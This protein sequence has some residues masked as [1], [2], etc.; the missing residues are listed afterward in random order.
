MCHLWNI[1]F[2][3]LTLHELEDIMPGNGWELLQT[4]GIACWILN[5]ALGDA[6]GIVFVCIIN[7]WEEDYWTARAFG[8]IRYISH[9][10]WAWECR[11]PLWSHSPVGRDAATRR[12]QD[13][14]CR[15]DQGEQEDVHRADHQICGSLWFHKGQDIVQFDVAHRQSLWIW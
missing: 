8:P 10:I 15:R 12:C 6:V 5:P 13:G 2:C 9:H 4:L 3:H 11:P 14:W 1:D 7:I